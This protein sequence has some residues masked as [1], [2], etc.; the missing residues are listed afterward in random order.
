MVCSSNQKQC[1]SSHFEERKKPIIQ[2]ITDG[3]PK[4]P[5]DCVSFS[6]LFLYWIIR[7]FDMKVTVVQVVASNGITSRKFVMSMI[8]KL[9]LYI[10]II[11]IVVTMKNLVVNRSISSLFLQER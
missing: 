7:S 9:T 4:D 11:K 8:E 1:Y 10:I 6:F 3:T 5:H 2:E